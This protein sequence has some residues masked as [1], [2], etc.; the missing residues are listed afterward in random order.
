VKERTTTTTNTATAATA[1]TTISPPHLPPANNVEM[2]QPIS[3]LQTRVT[4]RPG[5]PGRVLFF[6]LQ[7][8]V[9]ADFLIFKKCPGFWPWSVVTLIFSEVVTYVTVRL[10]SRENGSVPL[11]FSQLYIS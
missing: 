7:N 9:R 2:L 10:F 5:F 6:R 1:A 3:R 4:I 11:P 8:C